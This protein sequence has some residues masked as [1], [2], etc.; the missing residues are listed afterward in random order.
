[1]F[2]RT[3]TLEEWV[4]S[5]PKLKKFELV[6]IYNKD[7]VLFKKG[8]GKDYFNDLPYLN[9]LFSWGKIFTFYVKGN[10]AEQVI[11][12]FINNEEELEEL[13]ELINGGHYDIG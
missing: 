1:M 5:N 2:C 13:R 12:C 10:L 7:R 11:S 8:N 4:D 9:P 3:D 6:R